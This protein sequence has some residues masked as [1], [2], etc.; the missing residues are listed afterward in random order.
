MRFEKLSFQLKRDKSL[1][2]DILSFTKKSNFSKFAL[3]TFYGYKY[4]KSFLFK[5]Q[6]IEIE[7]E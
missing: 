5:L 3:D 4:D 1:N 6:V 2:R 7:K